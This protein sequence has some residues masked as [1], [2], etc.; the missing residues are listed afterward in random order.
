MSQEK[1]L[2]KIIMRPCCKEDHNIVRISCDVTRCTGFLIQMAYHKK[3]TP[4]AEY[5]Y[6][7]YGVF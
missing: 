7:K 6:T 2:C 5:S 3:A 4:S 1:R